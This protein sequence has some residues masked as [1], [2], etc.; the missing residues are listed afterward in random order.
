MHGIYG[1]NTHARWHKAETESS[2]E[3][4]LG[5]QGTVPDHR[6]VEEVDYPLSMA[7]EA[8]IVGDHADGCSFPV[9]ITQKS[10]YSLAVL[11]VKIPGRFI[12]KED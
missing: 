12:G 6:A 5:F 8:R 1:T 2:C 11:G 10:H 7:G 3:N 9:Q 4:R